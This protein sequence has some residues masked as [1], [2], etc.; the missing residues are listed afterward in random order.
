V[1]ETLHHRACRADANG[2]CIQLHRHG[3][4][5]QGGE[6]VHHSRRRARVARLDVTESNSGWTLKIH[7]LLINE[8]NFFDR[9]GG[10]SPY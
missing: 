1:R 8:P 4:D 2:V 6:G 9:T 5:E 10:A 7:T 3:P